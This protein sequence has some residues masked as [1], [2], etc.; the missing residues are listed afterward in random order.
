[1]K[2]EKLTAP[3]SGAFT[4]QGLNDRRRTAGLQFFNH[5][6]IL[7]CHHRHKV[8]ADPIVTHSLGASLP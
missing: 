2:T 5:E 6:K 3:K 1:M 4:P 7:Y 8:G